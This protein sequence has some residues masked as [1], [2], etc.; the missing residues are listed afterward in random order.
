MKLLHKIDK[1]VAIFTN[2]LSGTAGIMMALLTGFV[3]AEVLCRYVF[4][5]PIV[6]TTEMTNILFPW[7][8]ALSSISIA[9]DN[10]NT[11][12]I[13]IKEK[14]SGNACHAAEIVVHII[15]LYFSVFMSVASFNLCVSLKNEIL[16]LTR[17][18][19]V[20]TYGSMFIGFLG[21]TI[22][23]TYNLLKYILLDMMKI[24]GENI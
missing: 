17:V 4:K 20:F 13:F 22:V 2:V 7:I 21:I 3:F 8:V 16:V 19:K 9:R 12:L 5:S 10:G 15:I 1:A 11:A 23:V 6:I 18:S 14:L 24:G